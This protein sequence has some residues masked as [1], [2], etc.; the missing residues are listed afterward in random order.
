[1]FFGMGQGKSFPCASS[2][3]GRPAIVGSSAADITLKGCWAFTLVPQRNK[4]TENINDLVAFV[5]FHHQ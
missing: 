1:M 5:I 2:P 4:A 3:T